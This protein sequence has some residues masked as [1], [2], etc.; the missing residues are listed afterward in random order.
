MLH[1]QKKMLQTRIPL[2]PDQL[3]TCLQKSFFK[4]ENPA[5]SL[6]CIDKITIQPGRFF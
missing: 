6:K 2:K 3:Q 5:E 1:R 4:T